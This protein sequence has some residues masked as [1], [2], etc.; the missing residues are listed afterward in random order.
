MGVARIA[1]YSGAASGCHDVPLPSRCIGTAMSVAPFIVISG[2]CVP[3]PRCMSIPG[4]MEALGVGDA[5]AIG[6]DG[7]GFIVGGGL[8]AIVMPGI[9]AIAGCPARGEET[10]RTMTIEATL[11]LM[12]SKET[13]RRDGISYV[14]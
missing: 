9:G 11:E 8:G 2:V 3:P 10:A 1:P 7:P 14:S 13:F 12:A 6:S 4:A 5:G